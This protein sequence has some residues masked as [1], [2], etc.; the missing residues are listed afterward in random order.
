[1]TSRLFRRWP[2]FARLNWYERSGLDAAVLEGLCRHQGAA[3]DLEGQAEVTDRVLVA[4]SALPKLDS[5]GP[6]DDPNETARY[7]EAQQRDRLAVIQTL[8]AQL[9][10]PEA[11]LSTSHPCSGIRPAAPRLLRERWRRESPHSLRHDMELVFVV[12]RDR[13][14]SAFYAYSIECSPQIWC[15]RR[16]PASGKDGSKDE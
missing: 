12:C 7:Q 2:S 13:P 11:L 15:E 6:S 5:P 1:M 9:G 14:L 4:L 3:I 8:A 16:P 10:A